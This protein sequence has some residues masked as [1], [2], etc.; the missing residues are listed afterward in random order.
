MKINFKKAKIM[1]G[2]TVLMM[3]ASVNAQSLNI[4]TVI[5]GVVGAAVGSKAL[6]KH[7]KTGALL[8]GAAGA[9]FGNVIHDAMTKTKNENLTEGHPMQ[10]Y[11]PEAF[12]QMFGEGQPQFPTSMKTK[13]AMNKLIGDL[14]QSYNNVLM[15]ERE[16]ENFRLEMNQQQREYAEHSNDP[17][18]R[19]LA[20]EEELRYQKGRLMKKVQS[21]RMVQNSM[22]N[23]QKRHGGMLVKALDVLEVAAASGED[24]RG[25]A[26]EMGRYLS[27]DI[28]SW[29]LKHPIT[30]VNVP[31]KTVYKTRY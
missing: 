30:G 4:G 2:L 29:N 15:S 17:R 16:F 11:A 13:M 31:V 28:G 3:N 9:V 20:G 12:G 18:D 1:I 7:N 21:Q 19:V 14:D 25:Y 6:E 22:E 24:V 8:G 10:R 5:G 26:Q 23:A 27:V